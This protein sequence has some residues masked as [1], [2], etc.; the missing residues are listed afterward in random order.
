MAERDHGLDRAQP[1]LVLTGTKLVQVLIGLGSNLGDRAAQLTAAL[2]ALDRLPMTQ[3]RD[4]SRW[5]ETAPV[6]GPGGQ[7]AFLNACAV[8]RTDLPMSELHAQLAVIEQQAGRDRAVR[9]AARTLDL[10]L[11]LAE[12][13]IVETPALVVPHPRLAVRRFVLAPAIEV[14]A[15]WVHPETGWTLARHLAHLSDAEGNRSG[16]ELL[17][18]GGLLAVLEPLRRALAEQGL[19]AT[20]WTDD[21]ATRRPRLTVVAPPVSAPERAV[22]RQRIRGA[23]WGPLVWL[24]DADLTTQCDE[25]LAAWAAFS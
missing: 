23:D 2:S 1:F 22:L 11:L 16:A 7:G 20:V 10:D 8:C 18:T 14:A 25:V 12:D 6:G 15:D 24:T 3:L 9:W 21:H 17:L 13:Q 4:V 5:H 19:P